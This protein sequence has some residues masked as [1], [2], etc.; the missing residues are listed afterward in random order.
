MFDWQLFRAFVPVIIEIN[1]DDTEPLQSVSMC[2]IVAY[3]KKLYLDTFPFICYL[4]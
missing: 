3:N 2:V 4:A 1:L